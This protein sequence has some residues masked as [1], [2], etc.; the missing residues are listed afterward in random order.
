MTTKFLIV[1]RLASGR[2]C[3]EDKILYNLPKQLNL[4]FSYAG[5]IMKISIQNVC[6][7]G[8]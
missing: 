7:G 1:K 2:K 6:C 4:D 5:M 3:C 8:G